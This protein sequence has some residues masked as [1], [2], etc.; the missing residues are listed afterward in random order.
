MLNSKTAQKNPDGSITINFGNK[1]AINNIQI[2]DGWNY[3]VRQYQP[4]EI[5]LS[6]KW[7]F[8]QPTQVK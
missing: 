7:K 4:E 3:L 5:L 8:P 6:G 2:T 1:G